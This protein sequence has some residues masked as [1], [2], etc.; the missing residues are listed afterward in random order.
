MDVCGPAGLTVVARRIVE[1]RHGGE[2]SFTTGQSGTTFTVR[3]PL[4]QG[5]ET[6]G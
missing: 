5:R 6:G 1:R 4:G 2:L 3:L